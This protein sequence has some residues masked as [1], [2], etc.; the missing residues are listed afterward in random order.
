MPDGNKNNDDKY[1]GRHFC[2]TPV[3][4]LFYIE[5]LDFELD[6]YFFE[7]SL[8]FEFTKYPL[9]L[10]LI[11]IICQKNIPSK[12][13]KMFVDKLFYEIKNIQGIE[14]F[15]FSEFQIDKHGRYSE[16]SA[17]TLQTIIYEQVLKPL[18]PFSPFVNNLI[19]EKIKSAYEQKDVKDDE[20][21]EVSKEIFEV[22]L[23]TDD[24]KTA[25]V[26]VYSS[27]GLY[28]YQK[29]ETRWKE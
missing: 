5:I 4:D 15:Y 8:E 7:S 12:T 22:N 26:D 29:T 1:L 25:Y 9:L 28:F 10:K 6:V 11:R 16:S 14:R 3:K 24:L 17:N 18:V 19:F 27:E 13:R 2:R 21:V 23:I 20:R